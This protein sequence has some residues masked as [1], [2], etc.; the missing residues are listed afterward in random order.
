MGAAAAIDSFTNSLAGV[1]VLE[2][3]TQVGWK[4]V[5]QSYFHYVPE[6]NGYILDNVKTN[7]RNKDLFEET[8]NLTLDSAYAILGHRLKADGVEY[9]R[10]GR[11]YNKLD[12]D[13]WKTSS[14]KGDDPR[15]FAVSKRYTDFTASSHLDLFKPKFK[16]E[17]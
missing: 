1:V 9:F 5:A 17:P 4:T 8:F 16:V 12:E 13:D 7:R 15:R 10:C 14:L 6:D 11:G 2:I 3:Q